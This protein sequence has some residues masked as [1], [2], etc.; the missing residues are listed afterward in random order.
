MHA[1]ETVTVTRPELMTELQEAVDRIV[2]SI[3]DPVAMKKT[4][5]RMDRMRQEIEQRVGEVEV[6]GD[7]IRESRDES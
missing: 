3:R 4:C 7:L 6:A 5:E 1:L 2:K